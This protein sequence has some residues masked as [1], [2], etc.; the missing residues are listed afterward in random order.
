VPIFNLYLHID[1]INTRNYINQLNEY[2]V[3]CGTASVDKWSEF[4]ATDPEVSAR[5]LALP[6]FL[7]CSGA[8]TGSTQPCEYREATWKKK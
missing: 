6:H 3:F 8:V 5:F 7:R 1:N 2:Y 4:L